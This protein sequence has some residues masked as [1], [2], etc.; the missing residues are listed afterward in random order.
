MRV[1][2]YVC[3]ICGKI[4][5]GRIPRRGREVGDLTV[6][7][8]RRHKVDGKPCRGNIEEAIVLEIICGEHNE[9]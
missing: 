6:M 7:F 4:T 2:K 3:S 9:A 8:P 5:A 1:Y